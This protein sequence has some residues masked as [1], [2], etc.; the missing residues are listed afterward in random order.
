MPAST[1][2][3]CLSPYVFPLPS[4]DDVHVLKFFFVCA[5]IQP[6]TSWRLYGEIHFLYCHDPDFLSHVHL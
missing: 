3:P 5:L 2:W 1:P 4:P 6:V